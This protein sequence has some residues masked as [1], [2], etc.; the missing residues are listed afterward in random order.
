MSHFGRPGNA[1]QFHVQVVLE[2]SRSDRN[3]VF[4]QLP[5]AMGNLPSLHREK[6][7]CDFGRATFGE[8]FEDELCCRICHLTAEESCSKFTARL[9]QHVTK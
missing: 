4:V 9:G 8:L 7:V 6:A 3:T 5:F 2:A 1:K